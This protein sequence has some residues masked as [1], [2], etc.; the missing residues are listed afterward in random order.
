MHLSFPTGDNEYGLKESFA[1]KEVR[2][3]EHLYYKIIDIKMTIT[4]RKQIKLYCQFFWQFI[5]YTSVFQ[6]SIFLRQ[7]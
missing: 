7:S 2:F 3:L 6:C 5:S 1:S 4:Q